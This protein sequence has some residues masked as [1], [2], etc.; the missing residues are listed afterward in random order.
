MAA[1]RMSRFGTS[2]LLNHVRVR[3]K[4]EPSERIG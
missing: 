4:L 1:A 3:R 2:E